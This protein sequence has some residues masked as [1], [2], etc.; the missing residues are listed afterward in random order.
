MIC[1]GNYSVLEF[2]VENV[3][4]PRLIYVFLIEGFGA[5]ILCP[6]QTRTALCVLSR[7]S[8]D[9]CLPGVGSRALDNSRPL[10]DSL[11]KGLQIVAAL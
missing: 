2:N 8:C 11:G 5:V 4:L 6:F 3:K 7:H 10:L 9:S 1:L